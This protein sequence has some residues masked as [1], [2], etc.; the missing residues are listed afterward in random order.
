LTNTVYMRWR[1]T[2]YLLQVLSDALIFNAFFRFGYEKLQLSF[3][4]Y[5]SWAFFTSKWIVIWGAVSLTRNCKELPDVFRRW[6]TWLACQPL[7]K[8]SGCLMNKNAITSVVPPSGN[9]R[10]HCREDEQAF[11]NYLFCNNLGGGRFVINENID[12]LE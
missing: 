9:S 5:F 12:W 6:L 10:Y 11:F 3:P 7:G 2:C 8:S 1:L 4:E